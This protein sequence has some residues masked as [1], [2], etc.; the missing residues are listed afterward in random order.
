MTESPPVY[1]RAAPMAGAMPL[2]PGGPGAWAQVE[3]LPA[4]GDDAGVDGPWV[5][6]CV[7]QVHSS[8]QRQRTLLH[9]SELL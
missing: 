2:R 6:G 1:A 8:E 4:P 7:L 3:E 9:G 5:A